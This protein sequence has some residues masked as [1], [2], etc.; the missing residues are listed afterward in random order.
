MAVAPTEESTQYSVNAGL[1][2]SYEGGTNITVKDESGNTILEYAPT[3]QFQSFVFSTG[4]LKEGE[5]Y[6][7]YAD[8]T[9]DCTF[10]VSDI[11]TTAGNTSGGMGGLGK[12][13]R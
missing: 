6:T 5:T 3:K 10:T 1:S 9:Q 8:D 4:E 11:T 13:K 2:S 12:M 7:I